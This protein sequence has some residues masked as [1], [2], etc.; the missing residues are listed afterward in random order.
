MI[1][2]TL[3]IIVIILSN[4]N[5]NHHLLNKHCAKCLRLPRIVESWWEVEVKMM[6]SRDRLL[7][8]SFTYLLCDLEQT[9]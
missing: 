5:D 8:D 3:V 9:T 2:I 4:N 7:S 1:L 6:N